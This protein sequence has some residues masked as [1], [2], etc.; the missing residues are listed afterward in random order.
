MSL[1]REAKN[2]YNCWTT[3]CEELR[4]AGIDPNNSEFNALFRAIAMWGE[5][6]AALR[7]TQDRKHRERAATTAKTRYASLKRKLNIEKL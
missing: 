1:S 4:H 3:A 2:E 7:C 6:L 5:A